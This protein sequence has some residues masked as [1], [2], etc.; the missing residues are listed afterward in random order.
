VNE[1][2]YKMDICFHT[3]ELP[4]FHDVLILSKKC[5]H[6]LKGISECIGL[7]APDG[8]EYIEMNEM[9]V[10]AIVVSKK[11]LKR[12]PLEK[13]KDVLRNHVF[14]HL[15]TGEMTRVDFSVKIHI[16]NIEGKL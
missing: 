6:G 9:T 3:I 14:P 7:L 5:P 10:E 13:I 12:L 2:R 4:P 1:K 11:L 16:D 8:Y 15:N